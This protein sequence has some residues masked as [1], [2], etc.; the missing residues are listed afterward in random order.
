MARRGTWSRGSCQ[1]IPLLVAV[2]VLL[3][4]ASVDGVAA[5]GDPG[6]VEAPPAAPGAEPSGGAAPALY[7]GA[8]W[9]LQVHGGTLWRVQAGQGEAPGP[10]V[11]ISGRVATLLS[12]VDLQLSFLAG[13]YGAVDAGGEGVDVGRYSV[14]V[15]A[16]LHPFFVTHLRNTGFWYWWASIHLSVGADF[17]I[18]EVGRADARGLGFHIGLGSDIP[19]GNVSEGWGLWLGVGYRLKFLR[20]GS[21]GPGLDNFDEHAFLLTLAYRNNDITFARFPKPAELHDHDPIPPTRARV[22]GPRAAAFIGD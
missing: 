15:Q 18:I 2:A 1:S 9:G 3:T 20:P 4:V 17:D 22:G 6:E 14:G 12:L 5:P 19:L 21:L 13:R 8:F 7:Q 10:V 11:G 16:H